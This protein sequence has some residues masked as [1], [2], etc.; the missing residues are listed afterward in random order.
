MVTA[1]SLQRSLPSQ[2]VALPAK[3]PQSNFHR[4]MRRD[5]HDV[6]VSDPRVSDRL[7]PAKAP[8]WNLKIN[9]TSDWSAI[10]RCLVF[11]QLTAC[12]FAYQIYGFCQLDRQS[13]HPECGGHQQVTITP[14]ATKLLSDDAIGGHNRRSSALLPNSPQRHRNAAS[15]P[16]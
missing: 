1:N 4:V 11:C 9:I 15:Q 6:G 16:K 3:R 8:Q 13:I 5:A 2:L 7:T 10:L 14:S 12:P